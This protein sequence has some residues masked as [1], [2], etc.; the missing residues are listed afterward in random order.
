MEG[1]QMNA[2]RYIP[3][4]LLFAGLTVSALPAVADDLNP[5]G[6]FDVERNTPG[7]S[8][9]VGPFYNNHF[10]Y[11][12]KVKFEETDLRNEYAQCWVRRGPAGNFWLF[13]ARVNPTP[14]QPGNDAKASCTFICYRYQ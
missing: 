2:K 13:S 4:A 6:T 10:C 9:R 11:L 3:A 5:A 12:S 1:S 7:E 8:F 14:F